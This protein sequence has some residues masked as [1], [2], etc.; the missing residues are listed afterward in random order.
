VIVDTDEWLHDADVDELSFSAYD[1]ASGVLI[2]VVGRVRSERVDAAWTAWRA[3]AVIVHVERVDDGG[4]RSNW[5]VMTVGPVGF[6]MEQARQRWSVHLDTHEDRAFLVF[7][8]SAPCE[9]TVDGYVQPG[10][11]M[12]DLVVGGT[13]IAVDAVC[14]RQHR[15]R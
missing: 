4:P 12:G 11:L 3:G 5:D 2:H 15:W 1:P 8:A 13:R 6:R 10:T 14:H 9:E 7:E